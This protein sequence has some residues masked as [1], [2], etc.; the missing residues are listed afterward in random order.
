MAVLG[1]KSLKGDECGNSHK[2]MEEKLASL[3]SLVE[4]EMGGQTIGYICAMWM[5][6][7]DGLMKTAKGGH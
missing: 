3:R 5:K 1:R 6:R 4:R 7:G 2:N